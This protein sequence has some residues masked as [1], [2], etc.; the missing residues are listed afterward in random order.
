MFHQFIPYFDGSPDPH[1]AALPI[2]IDG[3]PGPND[4]PTTALLL[5]TN[6]LQFN[7]YHLEDD[8]YEW[9]VESIIKAGAN[10]NVADTQDRTLLCRILT[11]CQL[12]YVN[13]LCGKFSSRESGLIQ[14]LINNGAVMN[15]DGDGN[16]FLH[17]L[18]KNH[19]HILRLM[20]SPWRPNHDT[21]FWA[22]SEDKCY[23]DFLI[24]PRFGA[25]TDFI[26]YIFTPNKAGQTL[27]SMMR[28]ERHNRELGLPV[29]PYDI[30]SDCNDLLDGVITEWNKV[31]RPRVKNEISDFLI[32]DIA[33]LCSQYLDGSGRVC[34]G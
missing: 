6:Y 33:E 27:R 16:N 18:F 23:P 26:A 10:V 29:R 32:P 8:K 14:L 7:R 30:K 15:P 11:A 1:V 31:N 5:S 19:P 34:V 3:F 2:F 25:Y 12:T 22:E 17:Q 20:L 24:A 28:E 4:A 9:I 21:E 13:K